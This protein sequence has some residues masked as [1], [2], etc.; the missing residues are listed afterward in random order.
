MKRAAITTPDGQPLSRPRTYRIESAM[1]KSVAPYATGIT[2]RP[3]A[4]RR[5]DAI[6]DQL[7]MHPGNLI[8]VGTYPEA[9]RG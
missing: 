4:E 5:R 7:G 6:A 8:V 3:E 2:S 9:P 1:D